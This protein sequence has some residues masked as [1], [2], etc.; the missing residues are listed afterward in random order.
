[1]VE[2]NPASC[3]SPHNPTHLRATQAMF[4]EGQAYVAL[5]RVRSLA[6]LQVLDWDDGC[7]RVCEEGGGSE[8]WL[9]LIDGGNG[10]SCNSSRNAGTDGSRLPVRGSALTLIVLICPIPPL[11]PLPFRYR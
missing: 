1:M 6:G 9:F 3:W 10:P 8:W 2:V 5:S 11:P 7:V 4:A